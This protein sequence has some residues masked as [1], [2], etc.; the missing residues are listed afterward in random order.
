MQRKAL[1][2]LDSKL[3]V[4]LYSKDGVTGWIKNIIS[5]HLLQ[6]IAEP[7]FPGNVS[8]VLIARLW[9]ACEFDQVGKF[10]IDRIFKRFA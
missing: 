2:V 5:G 8:M 3:E 7:Y 9:Y 1:L 4:S 10:N 6:C